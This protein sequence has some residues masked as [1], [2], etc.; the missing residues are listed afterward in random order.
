[1]GIRGVL[2]VGVAV[3]V[4]IVG[5]GADEAE[6]GEVGQAAHPPEGP[7]DLAGLLLRRFRGG[8]SVGSLKLTRDRL[9]LDLRK[10]GRRRG[11]GGLSRA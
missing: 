8:I 10:D 11:D 3:F 4:S 9:L 1:M 7:P 5:D 6:Y 2:F